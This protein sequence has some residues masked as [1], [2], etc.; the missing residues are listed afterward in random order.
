M[1]IKDQNQVWLKVQRLKNTLFPRMFFKFYKNQLFSLFT[2]PFFFPSNKKI[3]SYQRLSLETFSSFQKSPGHK[4]QTFSWKFTPIID[5]SASKAP[6]LNYKP[7]F[8]A[9]WRNAIQIQTRKGFKNKNHASTYYPLLP[10]RNFTFMKLLQKPFRTK[11]QHSHFAFQAQ[12]EKKRKTSIIHFIM[13]PIILI[14]ITSS[15]NKFHHYSVISG[16]FL[17]SFAEKLTKK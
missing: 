17:F 15:K 13:H 5:F 10:P 3:H 11:Q 6:K 7:L 12:K 9:Q 14:H 16:I 4:T 1:K 2:F 8:W